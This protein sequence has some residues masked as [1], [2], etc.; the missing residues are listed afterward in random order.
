MPRWFGPDGSGPVRRCRCCPERPSG[1]PTPG[2][3]D[4]PPEDP[5]DRLH[6]LGPGDHEPVVDDGGRD[7]GELSAPGHRLVVVDLTG[8]RVAA[9]H[10]GRAGGV[11]AGPGGHGGERGA[12]GEV[13]AVGEVGA[14]QGPH[15]RVLSGG[16][17]GGPGDEAVRVE[18]V[19]PPGPFEAVLDALGAA[20]RRQALGHGVEGALAVPALEHR[21]QLLRF[22]R[23]PGIQ[24]EGPPAH[25]DRL[26]G[27]GALGVE[28]LEGRVEAT[29]AQVA[30]G[31]DHV[32]PH[33]DAHGGT[34]PGGGPRLPGLHRRPR[35][36]GPTRR[37]PP[38]ATPR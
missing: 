38:G 3:G 10:L 37:I 16:L 25:H 23:C 17:G 22:G 18:G 34:N 8:V 2:A 28:P 30:P 29:H 32:G 4:G 20:E 14:E 15:Q 31:T 5:H 7:A 36:G 13:L 21:A 9:E 6:L 24:L 11:E 27:E 26:T 35:P 12:V 1:G 19:D 33:V